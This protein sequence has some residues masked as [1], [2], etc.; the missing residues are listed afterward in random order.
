M[1]SNLFAPLF[2]NA[3]RVAAIQRHQI[4]KYGGAQGIR[5]ID[6]LESAVFAPRHT[7]EGTYL[8]SDLFEMAAAY[9]YHLSENQ[10]FLDGNKRTGMAASLVFLEMNSILLIVDQ[11]AYEALMRRVA[12]KQVRKSEI[13]QF[14]R[15]S[16]SH[17]GL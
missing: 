16:F 10:P 13:A 14:L 9:A 7:Y 8:H 15:A 6:A 12:I 4:E 2:L 17:S 3:K 1:P 11:A 5:D